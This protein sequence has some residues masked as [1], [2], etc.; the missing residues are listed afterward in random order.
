MTA[1]DPVTPWMAEQIARRDGYRCVAPEIDRDSGWCRDRWGNVITH[2]PADR[3]DPVK[4]TIAHVKDADGQSV[5]LRAPSDFTH[6]LL[7][8]WGHH[9]GAGM[10]GGYCWGTSR[11]ALDKQRRY[12]SRFS[13]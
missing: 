2:W 13:R 9:E 11:E 5:G 7:L 3:L 1:K 12:L 8:C 4:I 10:K 6:L